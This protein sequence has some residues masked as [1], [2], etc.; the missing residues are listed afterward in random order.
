MK[1]KR[2][3]KCRIKSVYLGYD[4]FTLMLNYIGIKSTLTHDTATRTEIK[5]AGE[6]VE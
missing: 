4:G 6:T 1:I 5:H 3:T 2:A